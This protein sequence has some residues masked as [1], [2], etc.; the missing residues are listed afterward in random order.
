MNKAA[1]IGLV[2]VAVGGM[3]GCDATDSTPNCPRSWDCQEHG[4]CT[5]EHDRCVVGSDE[6]CRRSNACSVHGKCRA[7]DGKCVE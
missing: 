1:R 5:L 3:A 7:R 6:D 2:L 4:F